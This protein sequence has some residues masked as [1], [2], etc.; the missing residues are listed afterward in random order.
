[1]AYNTDYVLKTGEVGT[2][3]DFTLRDDNGPVNLTGWTVTMSARKDEE[4]AVI[5]GASCA[6]A[7]NQS[8]TGKGKGSHTFT[9]ETAGIVAG[10]Y[11]LE[12]KGVTPAGDVYYFPKSKTNPY[13]VLTVIEPLS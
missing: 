13:A 10:V 6:I 9:E 11:K 7:A 1:M 12:F 8:T 4:P 5:V 3:M 2:V